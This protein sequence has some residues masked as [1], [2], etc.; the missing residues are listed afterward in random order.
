MVGNTLPGFYGAAYPSICVSILCANHEHSLAHETIITR[1]ARLIWLADLRLVGFDV[2]P[3]RR[4]KD[5]AP[6]RPFPRRA[7]GVVEAQTPQRP[8]K[9]V[10]IG[11]RPQ[12]N[13]KKAAH[14]MRRHK[15]DIDK[16][17]GLFRKR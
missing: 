6:S 4:P 5:H 7:R 3:S 13:S 12:L 8:L 1:F 15:I 14:R 17:I 2:S 9:A 11:K 10:Y 16:R